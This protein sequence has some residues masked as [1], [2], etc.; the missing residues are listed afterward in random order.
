MTHNAEV[1]PPWVL[2]YYYYWYIINNSTE[3]LDC[4][5]GV[6]LCSVSTLCTVLW[7]VTALRCEVNNWM[8]PLI[9]KVQGGEREGREG[10]MGETGQSS[11]QSP[12]RE[13][14]DGKH[15]ATSLSLSVLFFTWG[16]V[17]TYQALAVVNPDS[18]LIA[19]CGIS[20]HFLS[21]PLGQGY[22]L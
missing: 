1:C 13:W 7:Y 4:I 6:L 18:E 20:T 15:T 8:D 19:G 16:G 2:E 22:F 12:H 21:D 3:Y 17:W 5:A 11:L 10:E 9:N 14:H